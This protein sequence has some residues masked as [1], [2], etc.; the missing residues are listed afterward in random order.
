[1][2]GQPIGLQKK[3][4]QYQFNH[5]RNS[6]AVAIG[7]NCFFDFG[8]AFLPGIVERFSILYVGTVGILADVA[9]L[10]AF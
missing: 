7:R 3:T 9:G 10:A 2:V 1:M 6:S 5:G 8:L 4:P